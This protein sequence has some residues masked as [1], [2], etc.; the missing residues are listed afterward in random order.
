MDCAKMADYNIET[1][2]ILPK[3]KSET[4]H[5]RSRNGKAD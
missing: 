4:G 2:T 3:K 5:N 1:E